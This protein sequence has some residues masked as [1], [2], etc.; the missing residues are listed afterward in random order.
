MYHVRH[1]WFAIETIQRLSCWR[2]SQGLG[3]EA[4]AQT[5]DRKVIVIGGER[6]LDPRFE[7]E[8]SERSLHVL[9]GFHHARHA[10]AGAE[11]G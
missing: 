6:T 1:H 7:H 8:A 10:G 3:E 11:V 2:R 5:R 9:Q 4:C